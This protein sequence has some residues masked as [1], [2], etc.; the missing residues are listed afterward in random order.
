MPVH[1]RP[2]R[3]AG[4]ARRTLLLAA[5]IVAGQLSSV[6][7]TFVDTVL[8]GRHGP[9]TLAGVAVGSAVWSVV[10][11]VL[12]GVL[13]AVPPSVSQLDGAGR[14]ERIGPLFRQALWLSIALGALLF[15]L[16]GLSGPLLAAM[17]IAAD[18]RPAA[19]DFLDG[20]R[21]GA[22]ALALFFCARYLSEGLAWTLPTM[23][24]GL[25]GVGCLFP[26]GHA[27]MF[28]DGPFPALGAAGLGYATSLVLWLQAIGLLAYLRW[29]AR[30]AG[31]RLFSDWEAPRPAEIGA[32]LR[33]GLPIGVAVFMEGSLFVATALLIGRMG[34]TAV[35]AHQVA[36]NVASLAFMVPLGIAM[37]TTVRI[38]QAAGRGDGAGVRAAARAGYGIVLG[39]QLLTAVTMVIAGDAI[40]RIYTDDAAIAALAG[41]LLLFAAAFQ[42]P[43]GIQALSSGA[44]RGLKDTAWPMAITA[45]AYWGL[46]MPLGAWLGLDAGLGMGPRGMWIGL[47]AGLG[48]AAVLMT[49]RFARLARRLPEPEP[50]GGGRGGEGAPA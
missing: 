22:P 6:L 35:G 33:L 23:V 19:S 1:A 26:L 41:A 37:A 28:G 14:H 2:Y 47:I 4:E 45:A 20:I 29:S 44:L 11:L 31:L 30:F 9:D 8:A 46:G 24:A 18:V 48:A 42:F 7:M 16:V 12:V 25:L 13:M 50:I 21:W 3:F 15:V 17:G 27:L 5:P 36:I 34:T 40:A 49:W 43:D 32:L 38:G 10:I 39:T